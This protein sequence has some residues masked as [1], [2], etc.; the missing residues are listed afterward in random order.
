MRFKIVLCFIVAALSGLAGC[1]PHVT[2]DGKPKPELFGQS[3][4]AAQK[5]AVESWENTSK[6]PKLID[7]KALEQDWEYVKGSFITGDK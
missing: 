1:S 6:P 7:T 2:G 3:S 4:D 5:F